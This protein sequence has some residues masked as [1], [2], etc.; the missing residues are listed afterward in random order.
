[1]SMKQFFLNIPS[2]LMWFRILPELTYSEIKIIFKI[3]PQ[4][5]KIKQRD[6]F[7]QT[8]IKYHYPD[9]PIKLSENNHYIVTEFKKTWR[10]I[11]K[12]KKPITYASDFTGIGCLIRKD[13]IYQGSWKNG[14]KYDIGVFYY[15]HVHDLFIGTYAD[16]I[17]GRHGKGMYIWNCGN[18]FIGNYEYDCKEGAGRFYEKI[19]NRTIDGYW[20][21]NY[22]EN[23]LEKCD[24][25]IIEAI[26]NKKCTYSVTGKNCYLQPF[27]K[28]DYS[29]EG[30][31][32]LCESCSIRC[33]DGRY[34]G[35]KG[36][37][38]G[39]FYCSCENNCEII[40]A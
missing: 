6:H 21:N 36:T 11:Y 26:N 8:L 23:I 12:I 38:A 37:F 32:G 20:Q 15:K 22:L 25:K 35:S 19:T 13:Y 31:V 3:F 5:K 30:A 28:T 29:R 7:W 40:D 9:E 27:Y 18:I 14:E 17:C 24:G 34:L 16:N 33:A 2:D 1:M 39:G 4:W 10:W